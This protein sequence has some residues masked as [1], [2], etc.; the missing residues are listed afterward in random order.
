M[1]T[2][3]C[4]FAVVG[5]QH[6]NCQNGIVTRTIES[7]QVAVISISQQQLVRYGAM[8]QVAPFRAS[9]PRVFARA[10]RVVL[11]SRRGLELG[12]VLTAP[13]ET[14][15]QSAGTILRRVTAADEL[16][17]MRI[18]KNKDTAFMGCQTKLSEAGVDA[19]LIDLE[20]LFDG[21]TLF[22]YFLGEMNPKIELLAAELA[23]TYEAKVKF[24]Q[25]TEAALAGC[26]PDCGTADASGGCENCTSCTIASACSAAR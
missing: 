4:P 7:R 14:G 23:E 24:R 22:F 15:E 2:T 12:E 5:N 13:I 26:G 9:E 20:L 11:R 18:E 21:Q 19:T 3:A 16:L 17:A 25:F 10:A 1:T 6:H 8:G